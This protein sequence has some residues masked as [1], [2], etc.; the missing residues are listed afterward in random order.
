MYVLKTESVNKG[1]SKLLNDLVTKGEET[2]PRGLPTWEISPACWEITN[3]RMRSCEVIGRWK[4][5][6]FQLAECLWILAG[7]N[8]LAMLQHYVPYYNGFSDD[9]FTLSGA[10]GKRLRNWNSSGNE[11]DQLQCV[12]EKLLSDKDSRQA[13]MVIFNPS[14]DY[15]K[16][17]DVPCT[18]WFHFSV[19]NGKLNLTV[20][21]RS[22]DA[23]WGSPYNL[24]NF[25]TIQEVMAGWLGIEVGEYRH[26]VDCLHVYKNKVEVIKRIN[27]QISKSVDIYDYCKPQDARLPKFDFEQMLY[28]LVMVEELSRG[29][30]AR[31]ECSCIDLIR[32]LPHGYWQSYGWALLCDNI[33]RKCHVE[34]AIP[35]LSNIKNEFYYSLLQKAC[36]ILYRHELKAEEYNE[37]KHLLKPLPKVLQK[38]ILENPKEEELST[39][40][41]YG[42]I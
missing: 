29:I 5:L 9:G 33:I 37:V 20:V 21:M 42:K 4:N 31:E 19:R 38:W 25:M 16:T 24:Y 8:D 32:K 11:I 3:P 17:C 35:L 1:Y 40:D 6:G 18:N 36:R 27:S 22:N 2:N 13:V 15:K 12:Y 7:K 23:I 39:S 41:G 30:T 28:K 34:R 14:L 26:I 10:Y